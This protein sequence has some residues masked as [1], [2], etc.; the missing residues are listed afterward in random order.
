MTG[1]CALPA[2]PYPRAIAHRGAGKLA[3]ENTLAAFR[4]GASFG[5]RM[6][7]FDVKL[8]G[9]GA[10]VLLHDATLDRTTNGV[11]RLDALALGQIAQLDAGS[12]H[13]PAYAGEPVPTL[14]AIAR[15]L[16][17][18]GFLANI[19]IKPVPGAE[20]R[21]G[22][23]VALDART[24]WAGA[25][26]PPL[27][28]SFSEDALAAAREAVPELP[29]ALLLDKLPADWLDRLRALDCV[30]LDANHR[31]LTPEIIDE[32]HAAGFRVCC[33]TVNDLDRAHLLWNAGLDGLIT[34]WVD[35]ISPA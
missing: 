20:W 22:A 18:N 5:Y 11:G 10:S 32:A 13:S 30:A 26:V 16:R 8:S 2:W 31:E 25:D 19:E 28:S 6:F 14:A 1:V 17:A 4:H 3:P 35:R 9:D 34:D 27:L 33:Y 7:E 15:Y 12:W 24:L 23:A 21:T 29:R